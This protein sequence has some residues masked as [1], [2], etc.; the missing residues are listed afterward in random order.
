MIN[1]KSD[2]ARQISIKSNYIHIN[3]RSTN[4]KI[5]LITYLGVIP[6]YLSPLLIYLNYDYLNDYF[7]QISYVYASMIVSFLSGMQWQKLIA[8]NKDNLLFL[9]LIALLLAIISGNFMISSYQPF[10]LFLCLLIC[11]L[12]D[13]RVLNVYHDSWYKKLRTNATILASISFLL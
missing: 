4:R 7:K 6:F 1:L 8:E 2:L 3:M 13:L 10:I 11:L 9:P 5:I 12:I